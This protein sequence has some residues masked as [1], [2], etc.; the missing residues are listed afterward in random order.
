MVKGCTQKYG[1]SSTTNVKN[2]EST[3][4][5]LRMKQS[6]VDLKAIGLPEV[7]GSHIRVHL[8]IFRFET[9]RDQE[10]NGDVEKYHYIKNS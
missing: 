1:R 10:M 7:L 2:D 5:T 6:V 9:T 8:L 3:P 4:N